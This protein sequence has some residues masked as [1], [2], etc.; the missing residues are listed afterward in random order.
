[1]STPTMNARDFVH[2]PRSTP[3]H[4]DASGTSH[5]D[6][7]SPANLRW[8]RVAVVYFLL[9][10]TL[11]VGMAASH[12]FRLKGLH[13]H[14]N[15]L[16]WVSMSVT[17]FVYDR[18]PAAAASRLARVH[19]WLYQGALPVMMVGL[20]GLLLGHA[21]LEP[22]VATSSVAM[23]AAIALFVGNVLWHTRGAA[24][25]RGGVALAAPARA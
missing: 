7:R 11:G 17:C 21:A 3:A 24:V 4:S 1:M 20:A 8:L 2:V 5:I 18:V 19:F 13:V 16:G 23:W 25:A 14:L 9:A 12:D 10:V 15:L 22:V 6:A